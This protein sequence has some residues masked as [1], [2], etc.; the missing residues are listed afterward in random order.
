MG[1]RIDH[2]LF[3]ICYFNGKGKKILFV[4]NKKK[5]KESCDFFPNKGLFLLVLYSYLKRMMCSYRYF[6]PFY[7]NSLSGYI[8]CYPTHFIN[9]STWFNDNHLMFERSFP[10][11]HTCF[12]ESWG[13]WF[14]GI[15][16][17]SYFSTAVYFHVI[18][19]HP[20]SICLDV[21]QVGSNA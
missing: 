14:I 13:N 10:Q 11:T 5:R 9:H 21:I 16:M 18:S 8:F 4:Q 2:I 12:R 19:W 3:W 15:Y 1:L 7:W 20:T 6:G 17:Y